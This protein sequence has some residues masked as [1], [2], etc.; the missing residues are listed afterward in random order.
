MRRRIFFVFSVSPFFQ[1]KKE[2]LFFFLL[3][4]V[5]ELLCWSSPLVQ[6][7]TAH[8]SKEIRFFR[9]SKE[10]FKEIVKKERAYRATCLF[11]QRKKAI[12]S[13]ALGEKE[14]RRK[15]AFSEQLSV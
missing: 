4:F 3:P 7:P 9:A 6:T 8:M 15:T 2:G 5:A 1:T 11:L 14:E 13:Y 12:P 10:T